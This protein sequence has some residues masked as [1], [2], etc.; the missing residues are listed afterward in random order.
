MVDIARHGR[1]RNRKRLVCQ[2]LFFATF[3]VGYIVFAWN[4]AEF[5]FPI[6][7]EHER[8]N[9]I[10]YLS[11]ENDP[12]C[13]YNGNCPTGQS[14]RDGI[15]YSYINE[16]VSALRKPMHSECAQLCL[17][18]LKADEWWYQES[19]PIV[20]GEYPWDGG[21]I[22]Q[23]M[24]QDKAKFSQSW[25][26]PSLE[27]WM[28]QRYRY[29][30]RTD[31]SPHIGL[32]APSSWFALCAQPCKSNEECPSDMK[33][34]G[35][36]QSDIPPA[37]SADPK[38]CS[39]PTLDRFTDDLTIVSGSDAR[40]FD[41]LENFA[42]SLKFWAPKSKLA[43]Y[44]LGMSEE[45]ITTVQKWPNVHRIHWRNGFPSKLPEH[46][47]N[48]HNYAWKSLAINESVHEYKSMFWLDAGATFTGPI[49]PIREI[50]HRDGIFLVKGQDARMK[51]LSV[52][53]TYQWFGYNKK[54]FRGGPHFA[55]GI[56][57][58]VYPSRY[59]DTIVV[60]NAGKFMR[61][62]W[63]YYIFASSN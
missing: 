31:P 16:T 1:Q 17:E 48:L 28:Q 6:Q 59:I 34:L 40:Y 47:N 63:N 58:H 8:F 25:E 60:P 45:Q 36:P 37:I 24:R 11:R 55:G 26:P 19:I 30:L 4:D 56:Q 62:C 61:A 23:Y 13:R 53:E 5:V 3:T 35:R 33:C 43:V 15:C 32:Q 20:Q 14:C 57:G 52:P 12:G 21:C 22:V 38:S 51:D 46:I 54:T 49:D 27:E 41:A 18:E 42:A 44:N 9:S 29:V 39:Y 50:I 7:I 2:F 10:A